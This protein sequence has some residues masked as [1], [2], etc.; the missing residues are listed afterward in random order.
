MV[1]RIKCKLV[2]WF[3]ELCT[4]LSLRL[5]PFFPTNSVTATQ[6]FCEFL[7]HKFSPASGPCL[8]LLHSLRCVESS[9]LTSRPQPERWPFT[10]P[11]RASL[12]GAVSFCCMLF[13]P[14]FLL[15]SKHLHQPAIAV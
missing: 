2:N 13:W 6:A 11:I 1:L 12:P 9:F 5:G 4:S 15:P 7:K 3:Q 14:S 8:F 10:R